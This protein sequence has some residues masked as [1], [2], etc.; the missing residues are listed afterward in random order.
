M[1]VGH[2]LDLDVVGVLDELLD[3]DAVVAEGLAR[4]LGRQAE[5]LLG[6]LV[7]CTSIT[8]QEADTSVHVHSAV[9]TAW[10]LQYI[11]I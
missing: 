11:S 1:R 9:R 3:E 6:L 7:V 4:L 2:Q 8:P 10:P 5:A